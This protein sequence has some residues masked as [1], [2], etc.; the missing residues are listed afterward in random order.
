M[1]GGAV[2]GIEPIRSFA[3]SLPESCQGAWANAISHPFVRAVGE[4]ILPVERFHVWVQQDRRFVEGLAGFVGELI[5]IAP[6]DDV[7]GLRSGLAALAP[8][9]DLFRAY[10]DREQIPLDVTPLAICRDYIRFLLACAER[11]YAHGLCAYYACERAYLDAWLSV[12][13]RSGLK[14][15]YK[16][17][18]T[19]WTSDEF[20]AYVH[21][22]AERL[23]AH[24]MGANKQTLDELRDAFRD[25]VDFEVRFWTACWAGG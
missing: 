15:P 8:E 22:L 5:E 2:A 20:D 7:P 12:R 11:G 10:I 6:D 4:G 18:I 9:L 19:N 3:A 17:W 24:T 21:W 16:E 25:T 14:G 23:D 1:G 13:E